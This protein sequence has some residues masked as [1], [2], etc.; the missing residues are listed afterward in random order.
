MSE[1]NS[2]QKKL[3]EICNS[4]E[5]LLADTREF[6]WQHPELLFEEYES[7]AYLAKQLSEAG[8]EVE[9]PV[10]DVETAFIGRAKIGAAPRAKIGLLLEYD[11]LPGLEQDAVTYKSPEKK[12]KPGHGCQHALL[13]AAS[14]TAAVALKR[15]AEQSNLSVEIHAFG[16]PAEEGG[17][18][19]LIFA[20]GKAFEGFD[21]V[22]AWHPFDK[23]RAWIESSLAVIAGSI[24]FFGRTAHAAI[25]PWE[26]R[27]A[28]DSVLLCVNAL[29]YMREHIPPTSRL[30]YIISDGGLAP[31]VVPDYAR[32][33]FQV[34]A[35][36]MTDALEHFE[37]LKIIA[38][39]AD[40]M[41][42]RSFHSDASRGYKPPKVH[43]DI[44]FWELNP[45]KAASRVIQRFLEMLGAAKFDDADEKLAREL[46]AN[47]GVEVSGLSRE[48]APIDPE[49]EPLA[50]STDVGD[51]S[52]VVPTAQLWS[53]TLPVGIPLH[54]WA[55]TASVMMPFGLKG[56]MLAAKALALTGLEVAINKTLREKIKEEF[57][58][59]TAQVAWQKM[60]GQDFTLE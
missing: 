3:L 30:H 41:S 5:T 15:F 44:G 42:W 14:L 39:A 40:K 22:L 52:W 34:R 43:V 47:F 10:F 21:I 46:Q 49:P 28:L 27:S 26:G 31:N 9:K 57:A 36:K 4:L 23:T 2:E 50:G 56:A 55:A 33:K 13:G 32:L 60:M 24:E 51:V 20:D 8:F 54:T 35:T 59:T 38:L 12:E 17:G 48:I 7:S 37:D 45:N 6:I 1:F 29:E 25:A 19:K 58:Q 18:G 11:A 53:T 16:T